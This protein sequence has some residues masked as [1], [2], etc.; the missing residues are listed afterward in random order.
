MAIYYF[1][2]TGT[3]WGTSTNWSTSSGGLGNGSVPTTSDDVVL[4]SN[5]GNCTLFSTRNCRNLYLIGY[6][7]T[8]SSGTFSGQLLKISGNIDLGTTYNSTGNIIF[9]PIGSNPI[10][11]ASNGISL[12]GSLRL[13]VNN[14]FTLLDDLIV[15]GD[16]Q[17]NSDYGQ[18]S[19]QQILGNRLF[20]KGSIETLTPSRF[21]GGTTEIV[22]NGTGTVSTSAASSYM[23]SNFTINTTGTISFATFSYSSGTLK[24]TNGT[25]N[26]S[27]STLYLNNLGAVTLDTKGSTSSGST[28]TS[29]SGIN[30]NNLIVAN[31]LTATLNSPLTV[32]GNYTHNLGAITF[33]GNSVYIGGNLTMVNGNIA[34][35]TGKLV[36]NGTG[37]W[38]GTPVVQEDIDINTTGKF[39]ISGTVNYNTGT[40][41]YIS[42][43]YSTS[44]STLRIS[45]NASLNT[46]TFSWNNI[47]SDTVVK[48]ITLLSDIDYYG[49]LSISKETTFNNNTI[50]AGGGIFIGTQQALLG[51][52][53]IVMDG[54]GTISM[55]SYH[56]NENIGISGTFSINT[57]GTISIGNPCKIEADNVLYVTGSVVYNGRLNFQRGYN[58]TTVQNINWTHVVTGEGIGFIGNGTYNLLT[59]IDCNADLF[60]GMYGNSVVINGNQINI[61]G[62]LLLNSSSIAVS[63]TTKFIFDGTGTVS[64][65]LAGAGW[66]N[67]TDINTSGI[68]SISGSVAYS[69]GTFSHVS[70]TVSTTGS[71]L[72]IG[73]GTTTL[74]TG[75]I[76][77][78]NI[79][80]NTGPASPVLKS[81]LNIGG[82][83]SLNCSMISFS[84][85]Y[86]INC[87]G[88][89][90]VFQNTSSS[91]T[92]QIN[93]YG[94]TLSG[95]SVEPLRL[96]TNLYGTAS[97]GSFFNGTSLYYYSGLI[98]TTGNTL[99]FTEAS[100][101]QTGGM[102]WSKITI[103]SA[104]TLTL[105]STLD[106]N[107]LFTISGITT[108]AGSYN[109]NCYNGLLISSDTT[110]SSGSPTLN[111]ISGTWSGNGRLRLNT[112]IGGGDV[113]ISGPVSYDTRT[114]S[115]SGSGTVSTTG[116]TLTIVGSSTFSTF[117]SSSSTATRISNTGINWNNVTVNAIRPLNLLSD[118]RVCGNFLIIDSL[119]YINTSVGSKL[120]VSGS[121]STNYNTSICTLGTGTAEIILNGT[122]SFGNSTAAQTLAVN[123]P[124]KID[125]TGTITLI[126]KIRLDSNLQ[127][128]SGNLSGG[129]SFLEINHNSSL[130]YPSVNFYD[131]RLQRGYTHNLLSTINVTRDL[132]LGIFGYSNVIINGATISIGR[133]LITEINSIYYG[134]SGTTKLLMTGTGSWISYSGY[135]SNDLTFASGTSTISIGN[136]YFQH[137]TMSYTSGNVSATG[138]LYLNHTA[139]TNTTMKTTGITWSTIRNGNINNIRLDV[140][141]NLAVQN[142]E[143]RSS[144]RIMGG[145][146]SVTGNLTNYTAMTG[147]GTAV[148]RM[149]GTGT[150]ESTAGS[151]YYTND[152]IIDTPS[153]IN[154]SRVYLNTLT[155]SVLNG[156]TTAGSLDFVTNN[157]TIN[158]N[159]TLVG[160]FINVNTT[161][162]QSTLN[163]N[164]FQVAS[165][166]FINGSSLFVQG[167]ITVNNN[168][169]GTT[170][171]YLKG[172][173]NW[174]NS[175]TPGYGMRNRMIM[176]SSGTYTLSTDV[177]IIDGSFKYVSG[178]L[179]PNNKSLVIQSLSSTPVIDSGTLSWDDV[180]IKDGTND[181]IG[182]SGSFY[183]NGTMS[184]DSNNSFTFTGNGGF[185]VGTLKTTSTIN[186]SIRTITFQ[187]GI[188]YSIRDN[189]SLVNS[190][191]GFRLKFVSATPG[192]KSFMVLG[193]N[194]SQTVGYVDATDIDSNA[195]Q[196]I[197]SYEGV[198]SN[199]LNWNKLD[200][201]SI[202]GSYT[203][204]H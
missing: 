71:T 45:G 93:V 129:T 152:I 140:I 5:S 137:A 183:A 1:R 2:N 74:V 117:G 106:M 176:D 53:N 46:G 17:Y 31:T 193:K 83:L 178:N 131:L 146:I 52:S 67:N 162:L 135:I 180:Y 3:D 33:N 79:S 189:L 36:F 76:I 136:V 130:N 10:S 148:F 188:T 156:S 153:V 88:G 181:T 192:T 96:R 133:N 200:P 92:T 23:K 49:L 70:G 48:T 60:V 42:G 86:F 173:G 29:S 144:N 50:Y 85:A 59:N 15:D 64:A 95:T 11:I 87:Y 202:G 204:I 90:T 97:F 14:T 21:I 115:Y 99:Y 16:F 108:F 194:A 20:V 186:T 9:E 39:N 175:T 105:G 127:Y 168:S 78:N 119:D 102:T 172:S 63:G 145:T 107:G 160:N 163:C 151:Y 159:S 174:S 43:S 84:G 81:D 56:Y 149:I 113:T 197:W 58:R 125:T 116:S 161:T 124:I 8:L 40:I 69:T 190:T 44:G 34:N 51:S 24:Y 25:V 82:L 27:G 170:I 128:V 80:F 134:T 142:F 167:N 171:V 177:V 7:G 77:W 121:F 203:F 72:T 100:Y 158:A 118:M 198:L 4:D 54:T 182:L 104:M 12:K 30:W 199:T 164:S 147:R 38:S 139:F 98:T 66:K 91:A 57:S 22:A 47:T 126:G 120:Y 157:C 94:G 143:N 191:N 110:V 19:N 101:I 165:A 179:I 122:G 195:G 114:L 185:N 201:A 184:I 73:S 55:N 141:G 169:Q 154:I 123:H 150:L 111:I 61:G 155:Y 68:I 75:P 187:A 26:T 103:S 6:T 65:L 35:G 41:T 37:T 62:G 112:L 89:L 166:N 138:T 32:I 13:S 18:S 109:I 28:T 132:Y 196:T